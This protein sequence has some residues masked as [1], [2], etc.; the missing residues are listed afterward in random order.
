MNDVVLRSEVYVNGVAY[1]VVKTKA[2][3][4]ASQSDSSIVAAVAGKK[5]VVLGYQMLCGGTATTAVFKSKPAGS[6]AAISM[7]HANGANGG[8]V[9]PPNTHGYFE[10]VVGEGL[11]LTTG[12]GATTGVQVQYVQIPIG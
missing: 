1:P 4:A 2:D 5:I 11:T 6:S 7:V 9:C 12:S 8:C 10:T 3:V